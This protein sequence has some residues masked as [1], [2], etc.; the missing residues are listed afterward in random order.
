MRSIRSDA[1]EKASKTS[2][3]SSIETVCGGTKRT[4]AVKACTS[5]EASKKNSDKDNLAAESSVCAS[6]GQELP[7]KVTVDKPATSDMI[8][9]H[10]SSRVYKSADIDGELLV[11]TEARK[12]CF[13][14]N[15]TCA[16]LHKT[17][18]FILGCDSVCGGQQHKKAKV[19]VNMLL[20]RLVNI[21]CFCSIGI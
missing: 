3:V 10:S 21:G 15:Y 18:G 9:S 14:I 11:E 20:I 12:V 17:N 4:K 2:A 16:Y 13:V 7:T 8:D 19:C 5:V 6:R 1:K